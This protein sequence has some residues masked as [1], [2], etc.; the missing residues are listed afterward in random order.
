[1][2][3]KNESERIN[4]FLAKR[5]GLARRKADELVKEKL[6]K[7]DGKIAEIGQRVGGKNQVE[8]LKN[9]KWEDLNFE[10]EI[11]T[12]LFYKPIFCVTTRKDE[13]DR[14]TIYDFLP[15]VYEELKPAGRLD[16]MSEG[17]LVLSNDG[18]FLNKISHPK[19]EHT[20]E[21]LVSLK[22][23]LEPEEIQKIEN[24]IVL[25]G[26]KLNPVEV[27]ELNQK[28]LEKYSF[29]KPE[30]RHFWYKFVLSEGRNNQIR[31]M[32]KKFDKKVLRL[33]RTK[34]GDFELDEQLYKN[35]IKI[36]NQKTTKL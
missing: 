10:S 26:Y 6:V 9:G 14:K 33:I 20:K 31:K 17:L 18:N 7:V 24:G 19:F 4:Q 1:M 15:K 32:C 12:I 35:K 34:H 8:I 36:I 21:Y 23:K 27:F 30:K 22:E 5:L 29:L 16:Y 11:K 28:E 3:S 2:E 25:D 13:L